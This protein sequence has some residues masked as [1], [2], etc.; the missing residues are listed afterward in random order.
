MTGLLLLNLSFAMTVRAMTPCPDSLEDRKSPCMPAMQESA[1]LTELVRAA[2]KNHE[3][4]LAA[5]GE[6]RR[7]RA[8][9][10]LEDRATPKDLAEWKNAQ[11]II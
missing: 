10:L 9:I 5:Q 3:I 7:M 1:Y 4:F 2:D 6:E 11:K 8:Q